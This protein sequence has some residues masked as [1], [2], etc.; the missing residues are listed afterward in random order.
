MTDVKK[1][2]EEWT[3]TEIAVYAINCDNS[4][5]RLREVA[6]MIEVFGQNYKREPGKDM[7]GPPYSTVDFYKDFYEDE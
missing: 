4:E 5:E 2:I 6:E 3:A 7:S 1:P